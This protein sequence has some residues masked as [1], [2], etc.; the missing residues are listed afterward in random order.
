RRLTLSLTG[1]PPALD[2]LD[3]FLARHA[4]DAPAAYEEAV[5]R[6]LES[7]HFG[8]H[9]ARWWLD[10]ARYADS[11][12]FQRDD[13]RD[14]WPYRDWVIR[15]FN[16]N[17]PFDEFTIAQLAG[18]LLVDRP[19]DAAGL[20]PEELALYTATGF[21]RTTPTNVEAGT[22]QEEARVNQVFDRVNT[23]SMVWLGLTMECAQCHDHKY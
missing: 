12:G 10:A 18:D 21:H 2:E 7:P 14:L 9:W 19:P 11:H 17:L 23:T 1:L 22:D 4:E 13:L 15:A 3:T 20:T 16:D 5:T 6:L 8:E